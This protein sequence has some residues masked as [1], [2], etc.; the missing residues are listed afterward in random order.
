MLRFHLICLIT[1]TFL[2][3]AGNIAVVI[4]TSVFQHGPCLMLLW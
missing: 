4:F 3:L 1:I 2:L